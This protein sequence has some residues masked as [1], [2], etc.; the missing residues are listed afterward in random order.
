MAKYS[1]AAQ[2]KV[3]KPI[4]K[5]KEDNFRSSSGKAT[6]PRQVI[7]IGLSEAREEGPGYGLRKKLQQTKVAK[8]SFG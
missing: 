7:A 1:K 3:A 4:Q 5:M 2:K 8:K 6:N